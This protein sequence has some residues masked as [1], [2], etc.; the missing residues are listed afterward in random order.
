MPG[1]AK[2]IRDMVAKKILVSFE[3][4]DIM[5]HCIIIATRP[6]VQKKKDTGAFTIPCT[7]VLL[8]FAKALCDL[9]VTINIIHLSI[10]KKLGLGNPKPTTMWLLMADQTLR[11]QL[12]YSMICLSKWN[13]LYFQPIL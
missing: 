13:H 4:N 9:A 3:D 2:F 11:I 7:I 6:H 1:Y 10:Y 5:Q 12:V 8:Y